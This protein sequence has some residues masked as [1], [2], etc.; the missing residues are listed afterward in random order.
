[1]ISFAILALGAILILLSQ[2]NKRFKIV[3]YQEVE[4]PNK[5]GTGTMTEEKLKINFGTIAFAIVVLL[6]AIFQP[7]AYEK[8]DSG[9]VGLVE[10]TL[11]NSRGI[12]GVETTSGV[13]FYNKYIQ[14]VYEVETDQKT[15]HYDAIS[16]IVKGGFQCQ[17]KPSF[18]YSVKADKASDMFVKLRQTIKTGGLKAVETTWLETA[19]TGAINDVSNKYSVDSIFNNRENYEMEVVREVS[20]RTKSWFEISQ[21]KT[22]IVPPPALQ[23]TINSKTQAV[24]QAQAA[25][26]Q[27]L[28]A[29]AEAKKVVAVAKGQY[30]AAQYDAKTKE[31]LSQPKMLDLYRAETDRIWAE[32]GVSPY[33]SNN[34]FGTVPG[35]FINRK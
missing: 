2:T 5:W 18:S 8:I 12:Q 22:N 26:L 27:K 24:Q 7:F 1:M 10:N 31:L 9:S 11:S 3:S 33:G 14:N 25:E 21:F 28:T 23:E 6:L 16:I 32:A 29:E 20:K 30:E 34:V 35:M 4:V 15:V 19:V 13:Q 17:I